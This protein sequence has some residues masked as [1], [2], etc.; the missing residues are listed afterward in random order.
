MLPLQLHADTHTDFS[1]KT[2]MLIFSVQRICSTNF[3]AALFKGSENQFSQSDFEITWTQNLL[4]IA[5]LVISHHVCI[6]LFLSVL[7]SLVWSGWGQSG[8]EKCCYIF[9]STIL[10]ALSIKLIKTQPH[11]PDEAG[12]R[13]LNCWFII[14]K[15]SFRQHSPVIEHIVPDGILTI[16]TLT[17]HYRMQSVV[18]RWIFC[19]IK[20][21]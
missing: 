16:G 6:C 14:P 8:G 21:K 19:R 18:E 5:H 12:F 7:S 20:P 9:L 10:P 1:P 11:N 4:Q 3:N 17:E 15:A 13:V 2:P